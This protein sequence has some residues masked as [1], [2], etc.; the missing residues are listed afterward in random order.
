MADFI[1]RSEKGFYTVHNR[2]AIIMP[3]SIKTNYVNKKFLLE[4]LF[5]IIAF[6]IIKIRSC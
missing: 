2:T 6:E 3:V 4:L 1:F 5:K